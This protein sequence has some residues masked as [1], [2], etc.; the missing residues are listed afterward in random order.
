MTYFV[1]SWTY[2]GTST[3]WISGG[4]SGFDGSGVAA[5][6]TVVFDNGCS[7]APPSELIIA[8][9][10]CCDKHIELMEICQHFQCICSCVKLVDQGG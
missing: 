8:S 5:V 9:V 6:S 1:S 2:Y 3:Q 4:V 7:L 10:I